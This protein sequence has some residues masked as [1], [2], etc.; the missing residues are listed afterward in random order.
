M[1]CAQSVDKKTGTPCTFICPLNKF[2]VILQY[3]LQW[4]E[5]DPK[6]SI[7]KRAAVRGIIDI[8][9]SEAR[10]ISTSVNVQD[11]LICV[12][13]IGLDRLE[14]AQYSPELDLSS[15]FCK[16]HCLVIQIRLQ[17]QAE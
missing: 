14:P 9:T 3:S 1:H 15:I 16:V 17:H 11:V 5:D 10:G 8:L 2:C 13:I 7:R 6:R 12:L 4:L